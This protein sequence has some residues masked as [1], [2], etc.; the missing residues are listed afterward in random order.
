MIPDEADSIEAEIEDHVFAHLWTKFLLILVGSLVFYSKGMFFVLLGANFGLLIAWL[1]P[2]PK[3]LIFL[4]GKE[5][6][7]E[8]DEMDRL[9]NKTSEALQERLQF[10]ALW[11]LVFGV[12]NLAI[13]GWCRLILALFGVSAA[14]PFPCWWAALGAWLGLIIFTLGDDLSWGFQLD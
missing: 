2:H 12:L 9:C 10:Q 13:E 7:K 5:K 14:G 11:A 4:I 8:M 3:H 6:Q 1:W